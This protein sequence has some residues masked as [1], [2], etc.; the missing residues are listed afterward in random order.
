M[1]KTI[2]VSVISTIISTTAITASADINVFGGLKY[3][4]HDYEDGHDSSAV[5]VSVGFKP[6]S[7]I[8]LD[9]T[10]EYEESDETDFSSNQFEGGATYIIPLDE[11][12]EIFTRASIGHLDADDLNYFTADAGVKTYFTDKITGSI[13]YRYKDAIEND[14]EYRVDVLRVSGS[15]DVTNNVALTAAWEGSFGDVQRDSLIAGVDFQF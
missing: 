1:K 13:S 15:F 5:E 11:T 6:L 12:F 3:K 2:L 8:A 7:N 14:Y 10:S 4:F 9:F